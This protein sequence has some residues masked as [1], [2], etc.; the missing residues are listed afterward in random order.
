MHSFILSDLSFILTLMSL[1]TQTHPP[2]L[3]IPQQVSSL[4]LLLLLTYLNLHSLL[5]PQLYVCIPTSTNPLPD[6]DFGLQWPYYCIIWYATKS[7]SMFLR[8]V[9]QMQYAINSASENMS[10]Q[11][12]CQMSPA[13]LMFKEML[14]VSVQTEDGSPIK[15]NYTLCT[16]I[17]LYFNKLKN[18]IMPFFNI[19]LL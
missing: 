14:I 5:L 18:I 16:F 15:F 7:L 8:I 4:D 9:C 17:M 10:N 1:Q 6:C 11:L 3:P 13:C 2:A 12:S 19:L